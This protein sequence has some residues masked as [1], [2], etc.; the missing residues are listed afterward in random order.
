MSTIAETRSE[1]GGSPSVNRAGTPHYRM[2]IGGEW[3]DTA[4]HYDIVNPANGQVEFTVAKGTT[5]HIDAAVNS[6]RQAFDSG[7]WRRTPPAERAAVFDRVAALI[8]ARFNELAEMGSRETG[9]PIRLSRALSVGFP[10]AHLKHYAEL[11]RKYE[12]T[13]NGPVGGASFSASFIR[14]TPIGVTGGICPWNFPAVFAVWKSI[15]SLACGNS[16]VLKVDEKTPIFALEL[17]SMLREAGLPDGVLNVVVGDGPI[18]GEHL[19]QHE[20]VGLITFT[21]STA[22]GRHVMAAAAPTLK[23]VMLELGGKGPNIVLEDADLDAAV[24]GSIYAFLLH[25][26]QAC[27][28][29]TRL[30]LPASIHDEF[31]DRMV[32]RLSTLRLGDPLD[33]NTDIGPLMNAVQ[34]KRVLAYIESGKEQGATVAFGGGVPEAPELGQGFWVTPTVLTNVDNH[35]KVACEEVFGPVLSVV[36]YDTVEEA[37]QI[38]NDTPY[39]LS[40]GLWTTDNARAVEIAD[41]LDAGSVWINDWHVISQD[42]PFGGFKQSGMGR[43][44]GPD[45]LDEFTQ[46][47]AITLDLTNDVSKRAFG[48]VLGVPRTSLN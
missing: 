30:L 21:G 33:E 7:E 2:F 31:V 34:L 35:M 40:A 44:L 15:P 37:I 24:D 16:V 27:E 26:G 28:S 23:R 3:V 11:T 46:D 8:G 6:A 45:A 1:L 4:E 9:Q 17:A 43:E 47:K 20:G 19:V 22:V 41:Q 5:E 10:Q 18:V 14:K 42:L 12:W 48:L 13:R 29:G 38:A 39:G 32:E 36:K 25:A